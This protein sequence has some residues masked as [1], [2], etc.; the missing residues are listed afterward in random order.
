[1]GNRFSD[2]KD[3]APIIAKLAFLSLTVI[4]TFFV[5]YMLHGVL[6]AIILGVLF[7]VILM[8]M[9]RRVEKIAVKLLRKAGSWGLFRRIKGEEAREAFFIQKGRLLGAVFSV[10]LV[11]FVIAVPLGLFT[12][13]V[14]NQGIT[15]I[16]KAVR[17]IENEMPAAAENVYQ[18]YKDK[19]VF[20]ELLAKL[21]EFNLGMTA[22]P[23]DD[24]E[25]TEQDEDNPDMDNAEH[26]NAA[27]DI[28]ELE[29]EDEPIR[30]EKVDV[31]KIV[32]KWAVIVLKTLRKVIG[33]LVNGIG[34]I[35][36][37]FFIM[38][39]VMFHIFMDGDSIWLF[40][41]NISPFG[42]DAQNRIV[43]RIKN[44]SRAI[45]FSVF[46]TAIIQGLLS[47][48]AF[49]IVGIPWLFWGVLL[50]VCSVIPFVGT[51]LIWVPVAVF[52]FLTGRT[53]ACIGIVIWCGLIVANIDSIIRPL[54]MKH[55]GKTGMS[56][57]VLFFSI[58]GGLQTFGLIGIIYGP[59]IVGI[60]GICLLIF[61]E[62]FKNKAS[63]HKHST[64]SDIVE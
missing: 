62:H 37:N 22:H 23:V 51:G 15:A 10:V 26:L 32:D 44:V 12:A 8:P 19:Y 11:F 43:S 2:S 6:H 28:D 50:G 33:T 34:V 48:P 55:G 31:T 18:K 35:I 49:A 4:L 30:I 53:V 20:R 14:V 54:L 60:C 29:N 27:D 63:Q 59:M 56:Y 52:L 45:F 38:L 39:F 13:S 5:I 7:A 16:P 46:G 36:F 58:L 40:L 61:S 1:M 21:G 17:W 24:V 64:S 25:K 57:M 41:K 47:M 3:W 9:H 42:E